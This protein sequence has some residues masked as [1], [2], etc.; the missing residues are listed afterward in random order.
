[1]GNIHHDK[2]NQWK[3]K[4]SSQGSSHFVVI[5]K[6]SKLKTVVIIT[7]TEYFCTLFGRLLNHVNSIMLQSKFLESCCEGNR[8]LVAQNY[9]AMNI[10]EV[11][12]L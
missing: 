10:R 12:L 8:H 2:T 6:C 11:V 4:L 1:M 9:Y 7:P 3:Y 5:Y